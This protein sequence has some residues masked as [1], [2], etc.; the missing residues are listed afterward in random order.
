MPPIGLGSIL[1]S[2]SEPFDLNSCKKVAHF[3]RE[4]NMKEGWYKRTFVATMP[5]GIQLD[6]KVT[7]FLSL[8]LDEV[9]AI[10]YELTPV[11]SDI[12]IAFMP[13]LDSGIKNHDTNWD[14]KF[15]NTTNVMAD[16]NQAF[17]E[18]HT[19]KTNFAT[20]TFMQAQLVQKGKLLDDTSQSS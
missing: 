17:I 11:D 4:L 6:I 2:T 13:Y 15:W 10:K 8:E 5:N 18:A 16:G 1:K 14:D 3:R 19:M 20:C 12:S 7:R 9:G